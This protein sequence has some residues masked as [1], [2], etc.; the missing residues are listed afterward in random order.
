MENTTIAHRLLAI[1][2]VAFAAIPALADKIL[3]AIVAGFAAVGEFVTIHFAAAIGVLS[4]VRMPSSKILAMVGFAFI[5][6]LSGCATGSYA[7]KHYA[8]IEAVS[9]EHDENEWSIYNKP[10]ENRLMITPPYSVSATRGFML[11]LTFGVVD[12]DF[13]G[14]VYRDAAIAWL[15]S[16]GKEC[17]ANNFHQIQYLTEFQWE[18]EY[19]CS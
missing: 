16:Q 2:L 7:E 3:V 10:S 18:V 5:V 14:G 4:S 17:K 1:C 19:E 8:D 6:G 9:F 15:A 13:A 12:T 11:G